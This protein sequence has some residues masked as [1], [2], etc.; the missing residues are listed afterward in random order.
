LNLRTCAVGLVAVL[1]MSGVALAQ[2]SETADIAALRVRAN[3]G[4]ADAQFYLGFA[5]AKGQGVP[6]DYVEAV[7]RYRKAAEQGEADAQCRRRHFPISRSRIGAS[8]DSC[9]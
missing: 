3:A 6:Q 7:S 5:Y 9:S 8:A 2:T 4:D 1:L